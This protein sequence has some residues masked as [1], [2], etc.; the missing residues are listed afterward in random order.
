M[1]VNCKACGKE[2]FLQYEDGTGQCCYK[3]P[4]PKEKKKRKSHSVPQWKRDK[5]LRVRELKK[6]GGK[7]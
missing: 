5:Q 7:A 1:A 4:E 6:A 3:Q 2:I